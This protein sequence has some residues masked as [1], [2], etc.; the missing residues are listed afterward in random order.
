MGNFSRFM[1]DG[2]VG[3]MGWEQGAFGIVG[4]MFFGLVMLVLVIWTLYWKFHALWHAAK[5]DDKWWFIALMIINTMGILE[6]AYLYYFS[7]KVSGHDE[8]SVPMELG[9]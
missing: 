2:G 3:G 7:K 5:H 4:G 1:N 8:K 9:K 6:I